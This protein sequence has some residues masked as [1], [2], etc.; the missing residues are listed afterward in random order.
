MTE[1]SGSIGAVQEPELGRA[2]GHACS[3]RARFQRRMDPDKHDQAVRGAGGSDQGTSS[4]LN[5]IQTPLAIDHVM[6]QF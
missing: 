6:D 4:L 1:R 3:E 2:G 5:S